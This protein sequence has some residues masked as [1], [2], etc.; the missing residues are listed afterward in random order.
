MS[1]LQDRFAKDL[2]RLSAQGDLLVYAPSYRCDPAGNDEQFDEA[3]KK[4][5][6]E[7]QKNLELFLEKI[8]VTSDDFVSTYEEWYSE[9]H[10]VIAQLIPDR[11][12]NFSSQYEKPKTQRKEIS[13]ENY[14]ILDAL[15]GLRSSRYG[16]TVADQSAAVPK[17]KVQ[18]G[19]LKS[20]EQRLTSSLFDLRTLVQ[21]ELL[22]NEIDAART[23]LK[24][25]FVRAAGAVAG[26]VLE[27]HLSEIANNHHVTMSKKNPGISDWND[28]LKNSDILD[29]VEWRK[30]QHL[31]DIRNLCD[32]NKKRD[33]TV[34]EAE[35]LINGVERIIKTVF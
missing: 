21:A 27:R 31:G 26:V 17:I 16:D 3:I 13:F 29:T 11:L 35:E 20:A 5:K 30:I 25:K 15:H 34:D 33:P 23:L 10:S 9:A 28:L 2:K 14:V 12:A 22:D 4:A 32:H 8:K 24:G 7:K 1:K 6:G 19:I 18:V